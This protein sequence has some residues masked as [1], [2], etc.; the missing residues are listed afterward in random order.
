MIVTRCFTACTYRI[1]LST[2]ILF[3]NRHN[4]SRRVT[5]RKFQQTT[6]SHQMCPYVS[7]PEPGVYLRMMH[8]R[9]A[10]CNTETRSGLATDLSHFS[11]RPDCPVSSA[12]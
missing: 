2:R 9:P 11:G 6:S 10:F 8:S 7:E 5:V 1:P 4:L 12:S 3:P